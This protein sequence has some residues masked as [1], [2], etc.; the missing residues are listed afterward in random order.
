MQP[1]NAATASRPS[2]LRAA[3]RHLIVVL[4]CVVN[5]A[6]IGW[7]VGAAQPVTYTSTAHVLINPAVGNPFAPTPET[8][9]QDELTSLET[10]A[11]VARSAEVLTAVAKQNRPVTVADLEQGVAISVPPNTQ[12]LEMSYSASGADVA[13]AIADGV[14]NAYLDNRVRRSTEV[15][16]TRIARV[17]TQTEGVVDD[18][19]AATVAAQSGTQA[20][21]LFQSELATALRN[22]LVS[23]RAQRSYLENSDAPPGSV[24]S[25][26]SEP[27]RVGGLTPLLILLGGAL[28]GL[29]L[30]C[31]IAWLLERFAGRV[32]S[33]SEVEEV[34][35]PVLAAVR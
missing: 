10:E 21:R 22:E 9:R 3:R 27:V 23:L 30:G 29:A 6:V 24:I 14:A 25:P 35:L 4:W 18:L 5:G 8:V 2:A 28:A 13:Q 33:A 20:Q 17:E 16:D 15:N 11:Q 26:A 12:V 1:Y 7:L 19:R 34:G 32:R 31:L